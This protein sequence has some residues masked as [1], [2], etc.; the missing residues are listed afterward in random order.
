MKRKLMFIANGE[1]E[2]EFDYDGGPV[3]TY[4]EMVDVYG[5]DKDLHSRT[6]EGHHWIVGEEGLTLVIKL[7]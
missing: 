1:L 4:A 5:D 7:K 2:A 6:V 3:P